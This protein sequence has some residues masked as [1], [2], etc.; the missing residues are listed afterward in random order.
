MI[1]LRKGRIEDQWASPYQADYADKRD[2]SPSAQNQVQLT[3]IKSSSA[4]LQKLQ[5]VLPQ[6]RATPSVGLTAICDTSSNNRNNPQFTVTQQVNSNK[7]FGP[8]GG[9]PMAQIQGGAP[10]EGGYLSNASSVNLIGA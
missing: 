1:S 10:K 2:M 4:S 3:K 5:Q 9:N 7:P 8:Y 6:G